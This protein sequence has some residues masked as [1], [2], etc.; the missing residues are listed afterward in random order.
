MATILLS[1]ILP[2]LAAKLA[3]SGIGQGPNSAKRPNRLI[4]EIRQCGQGQQRLLNPAT[5]VI[6]ALLCPTHPVMAQRPPGKS[7]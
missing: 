4:P 6:D 5:W 2:G 3:S 1:P 7:V